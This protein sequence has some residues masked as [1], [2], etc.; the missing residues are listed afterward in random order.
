M[1]LTLYEKEKE[2]EIR[3]AFNDAWSEG[4]SPQ[5][6]SNIEGDCMKHPLCYSEKADFESALEEVILLVRG[7]EKFFCRYVG[8][9]SL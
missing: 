5:F 1:T 4:L 3:R 9:L 7:G 8:S 2:E 6:L